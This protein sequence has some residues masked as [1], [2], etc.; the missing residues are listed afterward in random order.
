MAEVIRMP[1]LSDTMEEG[2]IVGWLKKEGDM[3]EPGDVL[4]EVE[5]DKATME[6]DSY[7]EGVLLHIHVKEGPVPVDSII[8]I[9]GEEGEDYE[10]LLK[11][12][13]KEDVTEEK[14]EEKK[15]ETPQPQKES[16]EGAPASS[17]TESG[18]IK[19]SPLAKKIASE[20]GIDLQ[21]ITG[22]GDGGRIIKKDVEE[23]IEK[24]KSA[25]VTTPAASQISLGAEDQSIPVTQMRKVIAKRLGES[26]FTSP[27][28]YVTVEIDMD[29]AIKARKTLNEGEDDRI[30]F[31]DMMIKAAAVTLRQHPIINSSWQ[32]DQIVVNGNINIGVA[33]AVDEGLLVPVIRNADY[34]SLSQIRSEIVEMAGR[35]RERKLQPE[36]MQGNT[37][38]ISNLGMFGVEEF[39]AIINPPDSAILAVG[40]IVEK[41]VVKDGEI[42]IGNTMK[43]TLSCDH[44]VI[45]GALGAQF[46]QT[47]KSYLENPMKLLR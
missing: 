19:A 15:E 27:H 5:T 3:I 16:A 20:K 46:L 6:L 45:D 29:N 14:E 26:K 44:R 34:K 22:T 31:N 42:V 11:E 39:T 2:V 37:F 24:G 35:A 36:E 4:A 38:T 7:Q 30:S 23:A 43:V 21:T 47:L 41:P 13:E 40:T 25:P 12:E 1:R 32:D 18:R 28:F 33:V 10:H 9:L 8:A 17:K